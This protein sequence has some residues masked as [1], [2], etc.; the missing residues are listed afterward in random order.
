MKLKPFF[1]YYGG[2][3][4]AAPKYPQPE[5]DTIVE[6]FAGSAGYSVRNYT[7]KIVLVDLNPDIVDTWKYLIQVTPEDVLNLPDL[8]E[9]QTVNDV[10]VPDPRARLL[11]GWW[12]N[13]A[14]ASPRKQ[15]SKWALKARAQ[16]QLYWGARV[17]ERIATQVP[18]IRHW[19]VAH[20]RYEDIAT[21]LE[22]TWFV[23]PP[24]STPA[25][26][27]YPFDSVDFAHLGAWCKNRRGQVIV[28]EQ[29]GAEWLP[30]RPF[31]E[32]RA[33]SGK[34]RKGTSKEVIW[35]GGRCA[36]SDPERE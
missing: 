28:C 29:Q 35:T 21:D 20:G 23:D 7:R 13:P 30:F 22:A 15:M 8:E 26:R 16:S 27:H 36:G 2:K 9:G 14:S 18:F 1:S 19:S 4:R 10:D 24:Y 33:T 3:Y 31:M 17:R 6:P 12:C 25:G 32:M 11:M 5:Y 34:G